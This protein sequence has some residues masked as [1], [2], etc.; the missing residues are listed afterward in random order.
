M[1]S[2]KPKAARSA[3]PAATTPFVEPETLVQAFQCL[4]Q[5]IAGFAPLS[6]QEEKKMARAGQLDPEFVDNG[7]RATAVCQAIPK[8]V[9][10]NALQLA[11]DA[12]VIRRWDAVLRELET[13]T[14]GVA[15]ANLRRKLRFEQAILQIYTILSIKLY[16]DRFPEDA[17]LQPYYDKMKLAHPVPSERAAKAEKD[18]EKRTPKKR[19]VK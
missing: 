6:R 7:V 16:G 18:E 14:K 8:T 2:K 13:F 1:A 11:S 15:G 9:G 5:R 19:V 17:Y 12:N 10:R 3:R 4:R